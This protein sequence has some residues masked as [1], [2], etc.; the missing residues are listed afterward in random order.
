MSTHDFKLSA[1][2][3]DPDIV[4][5]ARLKQAVGSVPNFSSC[6]IFNALDEAK[7]RLNENPEGVDVIF[8]SFQFEPKQTAG[9]IESVKAS[10]AGQDAAFVLVQ[11]GQDQEKGSVASQMMSGFDGFL[12]EPYS[13][14]A[15]IEM[16]RLVTHVRRDRAAAREAI[17]AK[18]IAKDLVGQVNLLSDLKFRG[19]STGKS[20][21]RAQEVGQR[22][23]ELV[24]NS[25]TNVME[26]IIQQFIDAPL[27]VRKKNL[28]RYSGVSER[29]RSRMEARLAAAQERER[30][31][32]SGES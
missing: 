29:V 10:R 24:V 18:L 2:I 1:L 26:I 28:K 16:T 27:L 4:T 13:V 31:K 12:C 19:F 5:R 23:K 6:H 21:K 9:F 30:K 25:T 22:L 15:L 17:A 11:K 8:V 20:F 3:I 14:D 32:E 7:A